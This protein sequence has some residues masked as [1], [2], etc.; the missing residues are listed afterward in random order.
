MDVRAGFGQL[1]PEQELSGPAAAGLAGR[2]SFPLL[3]RSPWKSQRASEPHGQFP[4]VCLSGPHP[5][6]LAL[7]ERLGF[8]PLL[9]QLGTQALCRQRLPLKPLPDVIF[10]KPGQ[11]GWLGQT[12][13]LSLR[14][15]LSLKA[16]LFWSKK[17]K[18]RKEQMFG[19]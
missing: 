9:R 11:V 15:K 13:S 14:V 3:P 18:P 16:G 8:L 6:P 7:P 1:G 4:R 5:P 19:K 10:P 2:L 12:S 17:C